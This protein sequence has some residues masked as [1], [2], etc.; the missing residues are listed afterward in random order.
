MMTFRRTPSEGLPDE[1]KLRAD[2]QQQTD[3]N[4]SMLA[5]QPWVLPYLHLSILM[6]HSF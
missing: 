4:S 5:N 6:N 3:I 1:N 2:I